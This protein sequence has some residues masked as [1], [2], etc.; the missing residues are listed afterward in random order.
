MTT[1]SV[2]QAACDD[3]AVAER[4]P[5]S[6]DIPHDLAQYQDYLRMMESVRITDSA[7]KKPRYEDYNRAVMD[8]TRCAHEGGHFKQ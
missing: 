5:S 7:F 4:A 8:V 6:A 3:E 2:Y 1:T